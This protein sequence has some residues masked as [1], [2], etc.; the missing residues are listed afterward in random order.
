MRKDKEA[1][2]LVVDQLV[3]LLFLSCQSL[4]IVWIYPQNSQQIT[5][6]QGV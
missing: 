2:Q 4:E 5:S 1:D 6:V 3:V